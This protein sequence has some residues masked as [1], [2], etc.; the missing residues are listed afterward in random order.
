M[1]IRL[2]RLSNEAVIPQ[3]MTEGSA[4]F[5]MTASSMEYDSI[6]DCYIYHTD[7]AVEI[8][9]GYVGLTFPRS[10]NRRTE[11]YLANSV[12]VIDSDYRGEIIFCY[13][14]RTSAKINKDISAIEREWYGTG[15]PYSKGDR[16]GQLVIVPIPD[17]TFKE[18][19]ELSNT[20][21][22][23]GGYGSTGI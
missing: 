4:G 3:R 15:A 19:S 20:D 1:E 8:P 14:L 9:K 22:G 5:D 11:A 6:L 12:G 16:I 21:R 17:V 10:S 13:K 18:V 2:K 23:Q 7:I